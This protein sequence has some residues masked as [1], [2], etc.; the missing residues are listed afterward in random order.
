[1][2]LITSVLV[3]GLL[4]WLICGLPLKKRALSANDTSVLQLALYL[5]H[6][7]FNLYS[8][9]YNSFSDSQFQASG[10]P[11]GFRENIEVI[12]QVDHLFP[13][14]WQFLRDPDS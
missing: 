8:G 12:A 2:N 5:E 6:L 13:A 4:P 7:E 9:A 11:A 1:M 14:T 3:L 10:F